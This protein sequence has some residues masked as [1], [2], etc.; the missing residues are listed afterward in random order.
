MPTAGELRAKAEAH[1]AYLDRNTKYFTVD[2]LRRRWACAASTVRAIPRTVL[3]WKNVGRGLVKES[4]RYHPDDV[5][6]YEQRDRE[7]AA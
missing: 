1:Q 2:D 4:R 3:P 5:Y 6:A 7:R